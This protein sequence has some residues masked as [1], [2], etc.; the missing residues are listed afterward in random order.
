M[1]NLV[2]KYITLPMAI[3]IFNDDIQ[4]FKVSKIAPVYFELIDSVLNQLQND[5]N[6]L[7]TDMYTIYHLDVKRIDKLKYTVNKEVIEFSSEELRSA[8]QKIME[9]YIATVEVEKQQRVWE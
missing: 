2:L 6:Q 8:T 9:E 4:S 5:F 3:K 1:R 7:R